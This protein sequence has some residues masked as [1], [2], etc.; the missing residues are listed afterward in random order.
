MSE[1]KEQ[2]VEFVSIATALIG[3]VKVITSL[4]GKK[5]DKV[6]DLSRES[7]CHCDKSHTEEDKTS[8]TQ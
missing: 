8:T 3:L 5:E 6:R 7:H 4:F 1:K 2:V